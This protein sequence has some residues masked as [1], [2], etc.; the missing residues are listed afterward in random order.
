MSGKKPAL[1]DVPKFGQD[2]QHFDSRLKELLE[3]L[4]GR[5]GGKIAKLD[6]D[7]SLSDV[8]VKINEMI[9]HLM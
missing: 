6:A 5:R 4:T 7:A 1:P 8:I 2:R 3:V 9:N